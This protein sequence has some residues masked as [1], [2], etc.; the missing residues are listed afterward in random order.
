[1]SDLVV[2]DTNVLVSAIRSSQ[3]SSFSLLQKTGSGLFDIALSVPL[4]LEYE[5]ATKRLDR[6]LR[7]N[8]A[9]IDDIIDYLCLVGIKTFQ[10]YYLW[11]PCLKDPKDDHVLELAVTSR[12]AF[13]ITYNKRDFA[14]V[15]RFGIPL[16]NP[17]EYLKRLERIHE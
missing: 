6:A 3:G 12:A 10:A 1:M 4:V 8:F 7:P 13:I 9:V 16:L 15:E 17:Y 11:R 14:G 2:I 5:E